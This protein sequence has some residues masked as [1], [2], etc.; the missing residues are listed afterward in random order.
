MKVS[1]IE[2]EYEPNKLYDRANYISEHTINRCMET[3]EQNG[4]RIRNVQLVAYE[5]DRIERV[6]ISYD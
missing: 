6:I 2:Q 3:L 5:K 4:Y 1:I